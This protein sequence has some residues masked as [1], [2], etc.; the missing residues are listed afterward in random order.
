[1]TK[2][3]VPKRIT[4]RVSFPAYRKLHIFLTLPDPRCCHTPRAEL[5]PTL[6]MSALS[7]KALQQHP[8]FLSLVLM[9]RG[10]RFRCISELL[11]ASALLRVHC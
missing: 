7:P 2:P 5:P 6:D 10:L 4:Y 1:M 11:D 9:V 8:P 3:S